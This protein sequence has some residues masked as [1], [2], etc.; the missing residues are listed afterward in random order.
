MVSSAS[1]H[2]P[3]NPNNVQIDGLRP[4]IRRRNIDNDMPKMSTPPV[5]AT[6]TTRFAAKLSAFNAKKIVDLL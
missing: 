1:K 5:A 2:D 4:I 3:A 6:Y